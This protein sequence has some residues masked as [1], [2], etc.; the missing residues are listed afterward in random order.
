MGTSLSFRKDGTFTIVQFTDIHWTLG[1]ASDL[2]SRLLMEQVLDQEQPDLVFYTG[3][4]IFSKDCADPR[5]SAREAVKPALDRGLPY[6]V[7]FGNHDTE[8]GI[9]R[10]ELMDV[11]QNCGSCLSEA[12]PAEING[13][14]NFVLE[15][16]SASSSQAAALLYG[17]DSGSYSPLAARGVGGYDWIRHDQIDWYRSTSAAYTAKYGGPLPSLAYFHIPLPEYAEMWGAAPCYGSR[18][19]T[20]CAP[21]INS[22]LFASLA[23]MGDVTGT[24]AGHDHVNDYWGEWHGVRLCYGRAT[25][26]N[27]YGWDNQPRGARIVRLYEGERHFDTWLRLDGGEAVMEQPLHSPEA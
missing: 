21:L 8:A 22:G 13:V 12:G 26:Y 17:F 9:D 16:K 19:E 20:V 25:G 7:V 5:I 6:A 18:D 23:E 15:V 10:E 14:G 27:T 11:F 2:R 4:I 3:D 1:E 24:F